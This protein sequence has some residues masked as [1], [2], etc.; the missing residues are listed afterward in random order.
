MKI[1]LRRE[2]YLLYNFLS[3]NALFVAFYQAVSASFKCFIHTSRSFFA[4][5]F[6]YA[7]LFHRC[8]IF[9]YPRI[10]TSP[11][12]PI[13]VSLRLST[14]AFLFFSSSI[15]TIPIQQSPVLY[16]PLYPNVFRIFESFLCSLRLA[17]CSRTFYLLST[18]SLLS[19]SRI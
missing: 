9:L 19:V 18:Y 1:R 5:I 14:T 16:T 12:I 2:I 15:P 17:S 13:V 7:S 11:C 4:T 6:Y 3:A 8:S 10:V